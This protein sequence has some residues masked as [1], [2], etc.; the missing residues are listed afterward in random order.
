MIDKQELE[1]TCVIF[2]LY[3]RLTQS[4]DR[5]TFLNSANLDLL[6]EFLQWAD[7]QSHPKGR[8]HRTIGFMKEAVFGAIAI[9]PNY[10]ADVRKA[11]AGNDRVI[12]LLE[13]ITAKASVG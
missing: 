6:G 7:G 11:Y 10:S 3:R 12:K 1:D 4:G 5:E 2:L 9:N 13:T 8:F